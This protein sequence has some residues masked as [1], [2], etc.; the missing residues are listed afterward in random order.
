MNS[1]Y[2]SIPDGSEFSKSNKCCRISFITLLICIIYKTTFFNLEESAQRGIVQTDTQV[3][4]FTPKRKAE[5]DVPLFDKTRSGRA[6]AAEG[7]KF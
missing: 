2:R 3:N 4:K 6:V 1:T 5:P 7:F